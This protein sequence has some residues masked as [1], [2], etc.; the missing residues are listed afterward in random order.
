MREYPHGGDSFSFI[1][2]FGK[3]PID[4]SVSINPV[5]LPDR[6]KNAYVEAF[7]L[8]SVYPDFRAEKL[9]EKIAKFDNIDKSCIIC[10]NGASDII[11][12]LFYALRPKMAM[13][14]VPI[15]YDYSKAANIV[16][17]TLKLHY[18]KEANG[19][20]LTED[21]LDAIEENCL[22]VIC[23]PNNPTGLAIDSKLV[24][25][26]VAKCF[27]MGA[28]LVVDECFIDF[29]SSATSFKK[30]IKNYNNLIVIK[31]FTKVFAMAGL[32]LGYGLSS[33]IE[34]LDK[35]ESAG[36][37]WNL[38]APAIACGEAVLEEEGYLSESLKI[39]NIEKGYLLSKLEK[40]SVKTYASDANFIFFHSKEHNL[41]AKLAKYGIII[42]DCS[43]FVGLDKGYYR[44][45]IRL[46]EDNEKLA[47]ALQHE[48]SC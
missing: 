12:K 4:F 8:A 24:D 9:R 22:C 43:N 46:R 10:A 25:D 11:Y 28:T 20:R 23:N 2:R 47:E 32:R 26:I 40:L 19:F 16:G 7:S 5:P 38:S 29:C 27:E 39:I 34:L 44:I 17:S 1:E 41:T 15:F 35:I 42:R 21:F 36:Q 33:N 48:L 6:V 18:L 31:A 3:L 14:A 37:S 45:G 13:M 30:Y